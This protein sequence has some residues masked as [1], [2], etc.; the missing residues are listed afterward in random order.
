MHLVLA[1]HDQTLAKIPIDPNRYS[2]NNYLRAM[3]RLLSIKH[4][5]V[6]NTRQHKPFCYLLLPSKMP[7]RRATKLE[8]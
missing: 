1:T 8:E 2:D 6:I 7:R 5:H 4:R 3:C